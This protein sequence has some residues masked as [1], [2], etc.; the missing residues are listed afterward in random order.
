[1]LT[2]W[3]FYVCNFRLC[4]YILSNSS[5]KIN[6]INNSHK[7]QSPQSSAL[8]DPLLLEADMAQ[9]QS[10]KYG[11]S[12]LFNN[13]KKF[14]HVLLNYVLPSVIIILLI[15]ILY[16]RYKT[17]KTKK[18]KYYQE[19]IQPAVNKLTQLGYNVKM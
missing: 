18:Q 5:N 1:M 13:S 12:E 4:L 3:D 17:V 10:W 9:H 11:L 19:Y 16:H 15:Y 7:M 6:P 14:G 8:F 2:F